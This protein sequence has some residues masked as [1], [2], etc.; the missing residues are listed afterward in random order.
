MAL[1]DLERIKKLEKKIGQKLEKREFEKI[2]LYDQQGIALD[3]KEKVIGLNL[4]EMKLYTV[5]ASLSTFRHLQ[6]LNLN[7]T[8]LKDIS[9][10]HGVSNLTHLYLEGNQITDI[11][12][13]QGLSNLT[14]LYLGEN[15]ITDITFLQGLSKLTRLDLSDNHISDIS[16]LQGLSQ[17][18]QLN[19]LNNQI[20]NISS[21][22]A[23]SNLAQLYLWGNQITDISSLH[24]LSNLTQLDLRNNYITDISFLQE[25][26]TLQSLDLRHNKIKELPEALVELGLEI[27]V[28]S[29]KKWEQKI[30]LHGNPLEKPPIEIIKKGKTAIKDYFDSIKEETLPVNEVKV[31][32]VGDGGAGKTS[33]VKRLLNQAFDKDEPKTH[34]INIKPW[35]VK[36]S[37]KTI[38]VNLWDFGGQEIMHATHQ[39]F[40]SKRSLYLL[41]LDGRKD[42][43]TE[44]WLKHCESFGGDSPVLVVINKIDENRGFELNRKFLQDKYPNI[45]SFYRVSCKTGEGI[46][47]LVPTLEMALFQVEM[48]HT[49]WAA[50]WFEVKT[51]LENMKKPFLSYWEYRAICSRQNITDKSSQDTLVDFLN[52]LGVILH[53]KDLELDDTH[54]LDPKW[55]TEAVYKIINARLL[56]ESSGLLQLNMLEEILKPTNNRDYEYSPDKNRYI[57][58]L[59]IKFELCYRLDANRVLIPD[60]LAAEECSF[61]FDYNSSLKFIIDYDFLPRSV[62]PRFIVRMHRDIKDGQQWRTGVVLEDKAFHAF[63]VVKSDERERRIFIYVNGKRKRDY[64]SVIRKTLRDINYSFEKLKTTELV[65]LPDNP[66]ITV[67]YEELSGHELMGIPEITI[68]KIRKRY[69]VSILLDGIEKS[70]DRP[71]PIPP[72]PPPK[73][74]NKFWKI[75]GYVSIIVAL[76]AGIIAIIKALL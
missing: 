24:G 27:N 35:T 50:S 75:I 12:F 73:P 14:H 58:E 54:V 20:N 8:Q 51:R 2:H 18:T 6:K 29:E 44:Y 65:P 71:L 69:S 53:F 41:V 17:L 23:L 63:A 3:E 46:E 30:Y 26:S 67:E 9:F 42:E 56:A 48:I 19:L 11:S 70:G 57:I 64:F 66:E 4:A 34:G 13:L 76:A 31:L 39:F 52:D 45:K 40:L 22:H 28:E 15:Q 16:F 61:D 43:K 68:G 32:L 47:A 25:L 5:P 72:P 1:R 36:Q 60:L 38:K 7:Y 59:M 21:L 49:T 37:D 62:M 74:E 10:L 55:V 33:L